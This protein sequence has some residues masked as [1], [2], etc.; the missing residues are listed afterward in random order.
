MVESGPDARISTNGKPPIL[1]AFFI[2]GPPRTG[3]T[4]LHNV[5]SQCAWLSH[6]T[7]ETRYF[8]KYFDRGIAWYR[9]HYKRANHTRVIGEVAPTYF[10]SAQARE[11]IAELIPTARIVCTF[12]DPVERVLSLYRLKRA[13]GWI[14]WA[15][16]DALSRDPEL[17]E[18]SRYSAHLS[19]WIRV[20]GPAQVMATLQEDMATDPQAYLNRIVDFLGIAR[21]KLQSHQLQRAL[22]SEGLTL[23]R[24]QCWTRGALRLA[25]WSKARRLNALVAAAKNVGGLR[26]FIGGGPP[27]PEIRPSLLTALRAFFRPEVE[28]MEWMLNRDL[29]AWK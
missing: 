4:W 18:S 26:F 11:R 1:P 2:V 10:A 7:K 9:T 19:E 20:F 13:Y 25:E 15:F 28:R 5:L 23:P 6:P 8:D 29:S 12:R 22:A 27:F 3:T 24:N 17:I 14:S 16:E 21:L